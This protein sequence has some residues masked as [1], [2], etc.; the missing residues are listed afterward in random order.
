MDL[1]MA[2]F[3]S[4]LVV[5]ALRLYDVFVFIVCEQVRPCPCLSHKVYSSRVPLDWTAG[6]TAT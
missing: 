6:W 1:P 4:P 5:E 2:T 3:P